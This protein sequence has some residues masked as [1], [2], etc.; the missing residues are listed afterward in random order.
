MDTA[1]C[2]SLW[3]SRNINTL[4]GGYPRVSISQSDDFP[5]CQYPRV[6]IS[7]SGSCRVSISQGD[8]S[9]ARIVESLK[10]FFFFFLDVDVD[11]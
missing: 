7:K 4:E 8:I 1:E 2:R 11:G 3:I 6:S 5:A 10:F 9:E